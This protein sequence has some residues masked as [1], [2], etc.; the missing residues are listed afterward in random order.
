V[1][2]TEGH[3]WLALDHVRAI[4]AL[5]VFCWHF[6]HGF[7]GIPIPFQGV[8][9]VFP[10]ALLDE[11]HVGVALFMVLSGYLFA[12]L[13]NGKDVAYLPFFWNRFLR[14]FPLLAFTIVLVGIVNYLKFPTF[15]LA[16]YAR[17]IASGVLLPTL[18]NGGWSLTVEAHFYLL[19]PFLLIAARRWQWAPLVLLAMAIALRSALWQHFGEIQ[20]LSYYTLVGRID[21]FL[22]GI[23]A[24]Q[25]RDSLKR[26]H[27]TAL[28]TVTVFSGFYAW[29]DLSGGFFQLGG[30]YPS[31][32]PLWIVLPTAQAVAFAV[33][34][35][36]YD[37]SYLPK[38]RGVSWFLGK[39]GAYSYSIYLLHPFVVFNL[40]LIINKRL[41][42]LSNIYV[43]T[44]WAAACFCGM[45][46]VG[47]ASYHLI[48]KP[49][50]RYR[51]R[52]VRERQPSELAYE[53]A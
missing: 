36:Y 53:A 39:I 41:M 30:R 23:V 42:D 43:A 44:A 49:F 3:H 37:T 13:L 50:L 16:A 8:P 28:V 46:V 9:A 27:L 2:S 11:G 10:L 7:T 33:L 52:Y 22:L 18:P 6:L 48:E 32:S 12:K 26:R 45:V 15:N 14:L 25:Y 17:D 19:L 51:L 38:D 24:F 34:I 47:S 4:A 1:R 31:P 21:Q 35:A 29:F 40:P 20:Y 5:M